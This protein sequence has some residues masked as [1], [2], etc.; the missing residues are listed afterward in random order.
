MDRAFRASTEMQ[1]SEL[2]DYVKRRARDRT[3]WSSARIAE[4]RQPVPRSPEARELEEA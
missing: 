4:R 2:L 3:W 1:E